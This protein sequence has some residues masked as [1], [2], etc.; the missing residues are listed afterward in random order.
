MGIRR[1]WKLPGI[2]M[3]AL[4]IFACTVYPDV[5]HDPSKNNRAAFR[6]DATDCAQAYPEVSSGVQVKQRI[7]CMNLKGW[8]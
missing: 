8:Y 3:S 2:L 7:A 5:N 6:R 4:F 1:R